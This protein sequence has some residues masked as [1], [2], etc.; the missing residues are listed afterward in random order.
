M[1]KEQIQQLFSAHFQQSP[2][3]IAKAPGRINL[4]GEHTDYNE[5]FVLPAS[6][7]KAVW[8]AAGKRED[9]RFRFFAVDLN[10]NFESENGKTEFQNTQTWANYLLGVISEARADGGLIGGLDIAF[11][12]DIPIGAGLSSSAA[13]ESATLA[14]INELYHLQLSKMQIVRLA[15]RGE[16]RFVGMNCGIMDMY[17]SVYGEEDHF[18]RI[19]CRSLE[20]AYFPFNAPEHTLVLCDSRVKHALVESEYNI[21][22]AECEAGCRVLQSFDPGIRSL[23][24][25]TSEFLQ[26]HEAALEPQVFKRCHY[27]V[28]ENERVVKACKAL[29]ESDFSTLGQL[30]LETHKGL[31]EEYEVSCPE[32]DFLVER[33]RGMDG[34]LGARIMGGGF[35]GCTLNLLETRALKQF[36][37]EIK[38]VY[39]EKTGKT[40]AIYPVKIADGLEVFKV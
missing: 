3:V 34:V 12:S 6:I 21:R 14:V 22:R 33:A 7:D 40:M 29:Q 32:I 26:K 39:F 20:H 27:V 10:E 31:M 8:M 38:G 37:E 1:N 24:D 25:V 13:L 11:S 30:M 36:S 18:L 35:G 9:G 16:N 4:L 5:G 17:A 28:K 2:Q 15:Q 19:D 23:R